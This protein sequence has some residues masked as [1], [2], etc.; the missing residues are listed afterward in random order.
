MAGM[1]VLLSPRYP[2]TLLCI[3]LFVYYNGVKFFEFICYQLNLGNLILIQ[4]LGDVIESLAGA[5]YLDSGCNK[6]TVWRCIRPMLEPIVSPETMEYN[7]IRELRELCDRKSYTCYYKTTVQNGVSYVVAEVQAGGV[8]YSEKETGPNKKTAKK[9]A[10]RAVLK[11][12]K[13]LGLGNSFQ[14]IALC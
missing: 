3:Y 9:L 12:L 10:A 14:G 11:H 7:P 6:D 1:L 5:I 8:M 13:Y 2:S 4:V